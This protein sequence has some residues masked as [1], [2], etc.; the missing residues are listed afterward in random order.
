MPHDFVR[1][2]ELTNG[3][4]AVYYFD[5]PHKQILESFCCLVTKVHDGDTIRVK[6]SERDFDF[7]VRFINIAAPELKDAG[8]KASQSWLESQ[9]LGKEIDIGIN[10]GL[11][12]EK[13]GRLLGYIMLDGMD[14]GNESN[15][16]GHSVPWEQRNNG[17]VKDPIKELN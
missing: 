10:P 9:L 15:L 13:W 1:F 12:V 3:Q 5:S 6:W 4:M 14:M 11:R 7:P 16:A 8:G 2:P 17:L